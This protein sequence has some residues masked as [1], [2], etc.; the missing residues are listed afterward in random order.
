VPLQTSAS[1][2]PL[3]TG[4]HIAPPFPSPPRHP[5]KNAGNA[6]ATTKFQQLGEAYQVLSNPELRAK[7]DKHGTE[8]LD[9][10]FIDPSTVFGMLFGS[11][12]G[13]DETGVVGER[14]WQLLL[15]GWDSIGSDQHASLLAHSTPLLYPPPTHTAPQ[16]FSPLVGE[17]LIATATSKGRELREGEI[18]A[19]QEVRG[20]VSGGVGALGRGSG[21]PLT[22]RCSPSHPFLLH[23]PVSTSHPRLH[24]PPPAPPPPQRCA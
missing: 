8:G 5:D 16:L 22:K 14:A 6:E 24:P 12:V 2:H 21:W 3:P 11:E 17:F 1:P 15:L 18:T 19:M 10:N 9:V 20:G 13:V 7:Y 4:N 23:H